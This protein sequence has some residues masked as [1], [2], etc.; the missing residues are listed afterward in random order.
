MAD[1]TGVAEIITGER[2]VDTLVE[3]ILVR[4]EGAPQ[5][6]KAA[7][8][9]MMDTA[10]EVE[11]AKFML[12]E[13]EGNL[14]SASIPG[15]EGPTL[16]ISGKNQE[17]RAAQLRGLTVNERQHLSLANQAHARARIAFDLEI[18]RFSAAK[19]IARLIGRSD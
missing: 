10:D 18:N 5:K 15:P 9:S 12:E 1:G 7:Q 16:L 11:H 13:A 19:A 14:I 3:S 4:L 17:T 6:I 8:Q 2:K